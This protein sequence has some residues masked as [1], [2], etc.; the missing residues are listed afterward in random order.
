MNSLSQS[1]KRLFFSTRCVI[2]GSR[3]TREYSCLCR[4]CFEHIAEKK[5][6][7]KIENY[8]TLF[9]YEDEIRK[10]IREFKLKN[11]RGIGKILA[12]LAEQELRSV[13]EQNNIEIII[14]VP[15]SRKR[16]R[17]RGFNQVTE[18]L[19][20]MKLNYLEAARVKE[21]EHMYSLEGAELRQ[22]NIKDAF[23]IGRSLE[24][25]NVL[26]FDD[27]VTTGATVQELVN[28]IEKSGKPK[29]IFIFSL[30][31]AENFSKNKIENRGR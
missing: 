22:K 1:I 20:Q 23:R 5:S 27:I 24:G 9:V 28:E 21:T 18:I 15:I 17:E 29:N 25:K 19:E 30:A 6:L 11:L 26:I 16:E 4:R 2:C 10:L 7:N 8:Y 31:A 3:E 12:L 14:P 13:I